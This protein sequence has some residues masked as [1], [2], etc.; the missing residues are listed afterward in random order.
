MSTEQQTTKVSK[1]KKN[2]AAT[3]EGTK[4]KRQE[5]ESFSACHARNAL[6]PVKGSTHLN[7]KALE[8]L[9][10]GMEDYEQ[11][12]VEEASY[13]GDKRESH[14]N[15]ITAEDIVQ[16][17]E[18][19]PMIFPKYLCT[20]DMDP[21]K[22]QVGELKPKKEQKPKKKKTVETDVSLEAQEIAA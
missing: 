17:A 21:P 6:Y 3:T 20:A 5:V 2:E 19:V 7:D 1:R 13:Y 11:R 18:V 16:A 22:K 15:L 4:K 8:F 12:L 14:K 10:K 9:A